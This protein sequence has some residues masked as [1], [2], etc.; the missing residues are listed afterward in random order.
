M[1]AAADAQSLGR[2]LCTAT[3]NNLGV[4]PAIASLAV[5]LLGVAATLG[6]LT[7]RR[8]ILVMA[9]I[10]VMVGYSV[11]ATTIAMSTD[12]N[13]DGFVNSQD[14]TYLS[15]YWCTSLSLP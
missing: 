1:P 9:G 7:W 14:W 3:S 15:G 10:A 6:K 5:I 2:A 8:A 12:I 11:I 13:G 4:L